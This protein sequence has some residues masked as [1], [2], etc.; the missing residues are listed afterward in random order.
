MNDFYATFCDILK[1]KNE[2]DGISFIDV[3]TTNNFLKR[4]ITTIYY[5]PHYHLGSMFQSKD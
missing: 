3:L 5:D 1:V 4:E 2:S